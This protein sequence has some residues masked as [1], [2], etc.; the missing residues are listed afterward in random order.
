MK[1]RTYNMCWSQLSP[2][3][4]S[5]AQPRSEHKDDIPISSSNSPKSWKVI[6]SIV[7]P[8]STRDTI[9][10]CSLEPPK[11]TSVYLDRRRLSQHNASCCHLH[12]DV[13]DTAVTGSLCSTPH[14]LLYWND[15]LTAA[16][17][18]RVC[19]C[20]RCTTVMNGY[21]DVY[22]SL[23]RSGYQ[24]FRHAKGLDKR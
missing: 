12:R 11:F 13:V 3:W 7:P 1:V 21:W 20:D 23:C 2:L 19:G 5:Q 22:C 17:S 16:P 15:A 4:T 24:R 14:P 10:I 8:R 18:T 9:P 6:Y